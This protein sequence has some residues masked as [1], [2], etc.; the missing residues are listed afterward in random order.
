MPVPGLVR[1]TA[2]VCPEIASQSTSDHPETANSRRVGSPRSPPHSS[3]TH[4]TAHLLRD[5]RIAQFRYESGNTRPTR[6]VGYIEVPTGVAIFPKEILFSPRK[7]AEARY[8]IVRWTMMPRG[9]HFAALEE[10]EL[11]VDDIRAFFRGLR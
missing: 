2:P 1:P 9:G 11:L 8:N 10:P 6:P 5:S 4:R 3:A 7:W